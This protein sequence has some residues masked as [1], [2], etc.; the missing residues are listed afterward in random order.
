MY[1]TITETIEHKGFTIELT[2]TFCGDRIEG[3]LAT[4]AGA[5]F[6]SLKSAR[7]FASMLAFQKAA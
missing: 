1:T 3:Q 7:E 2:T 4:V 6:T 5:S